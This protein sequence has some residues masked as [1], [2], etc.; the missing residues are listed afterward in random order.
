MHR[1]LCY[2]GLTATRFLFFQKSEH[3]LSYKPVPFASGPHQLP[4]STVISA[5][6]PAAF[7]PSNAAF[8]VFV[9]SSKPQFKTTDIRDNKSEPLLPMEE[10]AYEEVEEEA[11]KDETEIQVSGGLGQD[12]A[13]C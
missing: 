3:T 8:T 1:V 7:Q 10:E 12:G 2:L 13:F 9:F 6:Y 4:Q 11:Q 5:R